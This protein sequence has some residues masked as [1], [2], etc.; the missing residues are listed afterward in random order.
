MTMYGGK[1]MCV[2]R[3]GEARAPGK[4]EQVPEKSRFDTDVV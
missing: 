4:P 1:K 3:N 2:R